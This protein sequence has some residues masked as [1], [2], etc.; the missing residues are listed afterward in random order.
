MAQL[1][2]CSLKVLKVIMTRVWKQSEV[3]EQQSAFTSLESQLLFDCVF[4]DVN[5]V[6][7][8]LLV[9]FL[10]MKRNLKRWNN[11]KEHSSWMDIHGCQSCS[12]VFLN[13]AL[14]IDWIG[15]SLSIK[16]LFNSSIN[17]SSTRPYYIWQGCLGN[18]CFIK[19]SFP[20]WYLNKNV[21]C[22]AE[23]NI[24]MFRWIKK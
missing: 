10:F 13:I 4:A 14:A 9:W 21:W 19:I 7:D 3:F 24:K 22:L 16:T 2:K 20:W 5:R 8:I 6:R 17:S 12:V 18:V 1:T 23:L 11:S 15:W